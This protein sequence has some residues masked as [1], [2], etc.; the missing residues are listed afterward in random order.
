M[1]TYRLMR[2]AK[3]KN[4]IDDNIQG[5]GAEDHQEDK[6]GA[7][8]A[9]GEVEAQLGAT[10]LGAHYK[11]IE[12]EAESTNGWRTEGIHIRLSPP[13]AHWHRLRLVLGPNL[14]TT[15]RK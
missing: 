10:Q 13:S 14:H 3:E 5:G 8:E 11:G 12:R 2:N 4:Q 1:L 6:A 7:H 15:H 9:A